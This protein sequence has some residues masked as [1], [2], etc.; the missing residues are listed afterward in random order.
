MTENKKDNRLIKM[1]SSKQ[2]ISQT[3]DIVISVGGKLENEYTEDGYN[4]KRYRIEKDAS[5]YNLEFRYSL[6]KDEAIYGIDESTF[7]NLLEQA[8]FNNLKAL[9]E[10]AEGKPRTDH[11]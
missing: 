8:Q 4:V 11:E 5:V 2:Y 7:R 1:V 9:L 10:K 3:E 6:T